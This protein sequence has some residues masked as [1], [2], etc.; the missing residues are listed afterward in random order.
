MKETETIINDT[1]K[2][3]DVNAYPFIL[4]IYSLK[5]KKKAL[6]PETLCT[7]FLWVSTHYT[8]PALK[9]VIIFKFRT[10]IT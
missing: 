10:H 4:C 2:S 5:K 8:T 1:R 9:S 7:S 6:L 3:K